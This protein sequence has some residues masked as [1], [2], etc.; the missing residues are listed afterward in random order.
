MAYVWGLSMA[1]ISG[2]IIGL[3]VGFCKWLKY[4]N[5]WMAY[6]LE[7]VGGVYILDSVN[8]LC[9]ETEQQLRHLSA[10]QALPTT[11]HLL[12]QKAP[13]NSR[14]SSP[15]RSL[16][17]H[18]RSYRNFTQTALLDSGSLP[19]QRS[20][21]ES[22]RQSSAGLQLPTLHETGG[23]QRSAKTKV[24]KGRPRPQAR[25]VSARPDYRLAL[26]QVFVEVSP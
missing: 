9:T 17:P 24:R 8:S 12:R 23:K 16:P 4:W 22:A 1:Y 14:F 20:G 10:L 19:T 11:T 21:S 15:A 7:V 3:C 13:P 25:S 26:Q 18:L 2:P 6:V 5:L